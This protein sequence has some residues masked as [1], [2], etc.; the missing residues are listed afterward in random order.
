[1]SYSMSYQWFTETEQYNGFKLLIDGYQK[2]VENAMGS[3]FKHYAQAQGTC[4]QIVRAK[5]S[6]FKGL[7]VR[8]PLHV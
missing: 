6:N 7:G 8:F 5:D 2:E 1:M 3:K 4:A